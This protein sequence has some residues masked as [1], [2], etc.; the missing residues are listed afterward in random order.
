MLIEIRNPFRKLTDA[1]VNKVNQLYFQNVGGGEV[2]IDFTQTWAIETAFMHNPD[3]Y[4]VLMK[5]A[6]KTSSVPN[7]CKKIKSDESYKAYKHKQK[8]FL[9]TTVGMLQELKAQN[10]AYDNNTYKPLPLER[11]NVLMGWSEFWQ[12]SKIYLRGCGNVFWYILRNEQQKP[13]AIYALP[14]H[15]MQI[16]IKPN[17]FNLTTESPV[18]GY[19]LIY[20]NFSIPFAAE[21]VIH[22]KMPNPEWTFDARQLM[23][24]SPLKSAYLNIENQISANKHLTKMLKSSGA[25]GFVYVKGEAMTSEQAEQFTQRIKDMDASKERMSKIT[26][27]SKEIGFQRIALGN[28]ELEPWVA[29]QWDRKTIC[30]VLDWSDE[31]MNNDGKASLSS[32]ETSEARKIVLT[33]NILPD[34]LMFEEAMNKFFIPFFKGYEGYKFCFDFSEMPELQNDIAKLTEWAKESPITM[35]EWRELIKFEPIE[36]EGMND[37]WVGK[38][39]IRLDEAMLTDSF[40]ADIPNDQSR[41]I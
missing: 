31:L 17:A 20:G 16:I 8:N 29:L 27:I 7:Y 35:N 9:P 40:L 30:N 14:S 15:L 23:G 4:A 25:F 5:M 41:T 2:S 11:P 38:T 39:K 33:D 13:I 3:V 22:I 37:V 36:A 12:L 32:T 6:T 26:G 28:D 19:Q 1:V 24:M 18:L 34:C 10:K 21:E